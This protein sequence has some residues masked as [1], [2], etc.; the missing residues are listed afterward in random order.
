MKSRQ[1]VELRYQGLCANVDLAHGATCT[2]FF[3]AKNGIRVLYSSDNPFFNGIPILFPANRISGGR[4]SAGGHPYA[5]PINDEKTGCSLHG[6]M[7]TLPFDLVSQ[8]E[9]R[10]WC[11]KEFYN[12][13]PGFP[14]RF[15]VDLL[16]E[17]TENALLQ[18][19]RV[20]NDSKIPLPL[21]FGFHTTFAVPFCQDSSTSDVRIMTD[22]D[23]LIERGSDGLPTRVEEGSDDFTRALQIGEAVLTGAVSRHYRAGTR[24]DLSLTDTR[25]GV[26]ICYEPDPAFRYRMIFTANP[27]EYLCL[28]PQICTVNAP[29]APL[30]GAYTQVPLLFQNETAEFKSKISIEP[31]G[32]R[33]A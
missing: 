29:N 16:Y 13:Y 30:D 5:L 17:L 22:V 3:D 18:T 32:G 10:V 2:D 24:G 6:V 27:G 31:P 26:R 9:S 1:T 14:Q 8:G 7:N 23:R 4:F 11:K 19:L 12:D 15:R 21:L 20:K 25:T 28:E 33:N